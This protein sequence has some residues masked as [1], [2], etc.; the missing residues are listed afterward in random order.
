MQKKSNASTFHQGFKVWF[1]SRARVTRVTQGEIA[2]T[3][4][5]SRRLFENNFINYTSSRK[6]R[7]YSIIFMSIM[8][9]LEK[10]GEKTLKNR[11]TW[12]HTR[13]HAHTHTQNLGLS[14][15]LILYSSENIPFAE[16]V[17]KDDGWN[18][19]WGN[20]PRNTVDIYLL[21]LHLV[22]VKVT[23]ITGW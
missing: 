11:E 21:R 1:G 23:T 19:D 13:T 5:V 6:P 18:F 7:T 22:Q 17:F 14:V 20:L 3:A 2:I 4:L 16:E 10:K 9:W 8:C 15:C 12:T